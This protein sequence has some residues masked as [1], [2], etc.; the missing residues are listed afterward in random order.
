MLFI[1]GVLSAQTVKDWF[2]KPSLA[3]ASQITEKYSV[4]DNKFKTIPLVM[5]KFIDFIQNRTDGIVKFKYRHTLD[6]LP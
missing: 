4:Q 2:T 1:T 3:A 6:L 5:L